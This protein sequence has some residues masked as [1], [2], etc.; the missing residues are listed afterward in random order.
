MAKQAAKTP[1]TPEPERGLSGFQKTI[2][3]VLALVFVGSLGARAMLTGGD[4]APTGSE[5][6]SLGST[7]PDELGGKS[8]LPGLPGGEAAPAPGATAEPGSLEALLPVFTE[9]SFFGLIGFALGYLSRKVFKL[10]L[11]FV[12]LLFLGVQGL[13]YAGI[14]ESVDW[15]KAIQYVNDFVLNLKENETFTQWLTDRVPTAGALT[16]GYLVG[17]KRG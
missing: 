1:E 2:F 7:D 5:R 10:V 8:F 16:A 17:L 14:I 12:A 4:A 6:T 13:V 3:L 9:A 15:P 11:I